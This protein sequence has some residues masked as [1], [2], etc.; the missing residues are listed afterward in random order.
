MYRIAS[1]KSASSTVAVLLAPDLAQPRSVPSA[2]VISSSL[3]S[4]TFPTLLVL[5][6]QPPCL[7][8]GV[9][10]RREGQRRPGGVVRVLVAQAL[11]GLG[12]LHLARALRRPGLAR[13]PGAG[14]GGHHGLGV[15]R[16]G[17]AARAAAQRAAADGPLLGRQAPPAR[18]DHHG[19]ASGLA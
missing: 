4:V 6:R 10:A 18:A 9:R 3:S 8:A 15:G 13:I 19:R 2:V 17:Q 11:P 14:S 1:R 12:V 16:R 7:A 5:L